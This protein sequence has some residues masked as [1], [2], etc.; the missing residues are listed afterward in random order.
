MNFY[1]KPEKLGMAKAKAILITL[2]FGGFGIHRFM[3]G[4][5]GTGIIWLLTCGCLGVGW[6][7]DLIKICSGT[8]MDRNG[9][10]WG[11]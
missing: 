4:K 5:T 1:I 11:S 10:V 3:A 9:M 6:L 2:F 7:F 8:F